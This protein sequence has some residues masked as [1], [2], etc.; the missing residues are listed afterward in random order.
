MYAV[1]LLYICHLKWKLHNN[2]CE[3][4]QMKFHARTFWNADIISGFGTHYC[5]RNSG[6]MPPPLQSSNSQPLAAKQMNRE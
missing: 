6:N 1:I 2:S 4:W 3:R 5:G